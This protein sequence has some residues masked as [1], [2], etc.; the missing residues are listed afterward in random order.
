MKL[1]YLF[2]PGA[3]AE[4]PMT[5]LPANIWSNSSMKSGQPFLRSAYSFFFCIA[6]KPDIVVVCHRQAIVYTN[7]MLKVWYLVAAKLIVPPLVRSY[8]GAIGSVS[9]AGGHVA[10]FLD[11]QPKLSQLSHPM[12]EL[13][14]VMSPTSGNSEPFLHILPSKLAHLP[15]FASVRCNLHAVNLTESLRIRFVPIGPVVP[16][17]WTF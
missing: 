10:K 17:L 2:A 7:Y 13:L 1:S 8:D 16:C 4:S 14:T 3:N 15:L 11:E 5:A 9:H 6:K 12:A